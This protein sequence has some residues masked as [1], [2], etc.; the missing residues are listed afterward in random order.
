MMTTK[1]TAGLDLATAGSALRHGRA[2]LAA[3][4]DGGTTAQALLAYVL[5]LSR[6]RL[7]AYPQTTLTTQQAA[8]FDRLLERAAAGEPLAYLTGRREFCGLEFEIDARVLVPRPET[9]ML[10]D[11]ARAVRSAQ[12]ERILDVG[13][14]SGC[15]IVAL[16]VHLPNATLTAADI[17][18]AALAVARRN[19]AKHGLS[20]RITFL[21]SDLLSAFQPPA[22]SVQPLASSLSQIPD[23]ALFGIVGQPPFDLITANLP[24][25]DRAELA[26]LPVSR[27]EPRVALDGGPGGL[28]LVE[29]LLRQAG[30]CLS[31]DG[32]LLLE[33][34]AQ[35]GPAAAAVART[36]FPSA[37]ISI[38]PDLAG[39]D[40]VLVIQLAARSAG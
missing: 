21:E 27:Y 14:G 13:T 12:A 40:R 30:V 4:D 35:Q 38:K 7:L 16:G 34:G 28:R 19:A 29:R 3:L 39:L 22:S 9:E 32:T 23:P 10:V 17:S 8:A 2:R 20:G 15:I 33:I 11:L 26:R 5:S 24:Y 25:I 37:S 6:E 1:P 31:P 18:P 36:F